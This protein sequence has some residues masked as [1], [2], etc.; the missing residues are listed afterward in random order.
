MATVAVSRERLRKGDLPLIC[1]KTGRPAHGMVDA[2]FSVL[3]SWTYLLLL[4]GVFP[5]VIALLFAGERIVA[6][7]PL[8]RSVLNR[9][10]GLSLRARAC[11]GV[12]VAL[13]AVAVASGFGWLWWPAVLFGIAGSAILFQRETAWV[14]AHPIH[15]TPDIELDGVHENFAAAVDR[16]RAV[17]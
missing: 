11:V 2:T 15:G 9:Y 4:A 16:Q 17:S 6:Q 12:A 13:A 8:R 7:V 1:I 10:H 3:P 5:F 14:R